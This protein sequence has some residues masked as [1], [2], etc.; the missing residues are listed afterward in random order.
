MQNRFAMSQSSTLKKPDKACTV[1][2]GKILWRRWLDR[3]WQKV[4]Y[5][6]AVCRRTATSQT[7][8][9]AA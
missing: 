8:A 3:D 1:C 6:G 2:G 9:K 5:C 7:Q 4:A